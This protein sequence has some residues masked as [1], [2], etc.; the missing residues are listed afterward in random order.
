MWEPMYPAPPQTNTRMEFLLNVYICLGA[1]QS[2][3][4]RASLSIAAAAAAYS[5]NG[6]KPAL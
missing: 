6:A 5:P 1:M 4:G 2:A 3:P